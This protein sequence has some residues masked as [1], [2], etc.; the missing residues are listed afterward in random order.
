MALKIGIVGSGNVAWHL[1]HGFLQ[2]SEVDV[3]WIYGRNKETLS[4]LSE[5]TGI[6]AHTELPGEAVD[7]VLVCVN[8]DSVQNVLSQLPEM[9]KVAYTSGTVSLDNLSFHQ[10]YCGVFYPL[11]SFTKDQSVNLKEVP[12]LIE[13]NHPEFAEELDKIA[14]LLSD[15][16]RKMD[17]EQRKQLHIA[18]VFSNNFVNHLL[19]L[20]QEHLKNKNIDNRILLPLINETIRKAIESGPYSAQSGPARR[21]DKHTIESHINELDGI[22]KEI[23]AVITESIQKTYSKR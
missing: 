1:A 12:F 15:N 10:K 2:S 6:K 13:A 20:A 3:K 18:A 4:E 21:H 7:L 11:Q 19:F 9:C 14:K 22:S 8:D 23:Y 5:S 16:V 17:S